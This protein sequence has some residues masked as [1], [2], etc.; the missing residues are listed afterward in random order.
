MR[1]DDTTSKRSALWSMPGTN[2]NIQLGFPLV[3]KE[4]RPQVAEAWTKY[5]NKGE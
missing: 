3:N 5:E 4:R 1:M 2:I